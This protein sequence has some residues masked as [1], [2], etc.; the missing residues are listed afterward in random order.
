MSGSEVGT[1]GGVSGM[2]GMVSGFN[3][4]AI[5]GKISSQHYISGG[6]VTSGIVAT[7]FRS[8]N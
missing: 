5:G 2:G 3:S 8:K 4:T 1:I 6:T 7:E